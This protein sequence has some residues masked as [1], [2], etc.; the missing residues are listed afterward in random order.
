[1]R[2]YDF[3]LACHLV[4]VGTPLASVADAI[5]QRRASDNKGVDY[6]HGTVAAAVARLQ[7]AVGDEGRAV[8]AEIRQLLSRSDAEPRAGGAGGPDG[9][10]FE[11]RSGG[12]GRD[13]PQPTI[14]GVYNDKFIVP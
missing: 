13:A 4:K 6:A 7:G 12:E 11:P 2:S 10:A 1:M 14:F 3:A 8:A 5:Q 9:T